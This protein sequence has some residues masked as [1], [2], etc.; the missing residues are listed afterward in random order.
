MA[1]GDGSWKGR[2]GVCHNAAFG[3]S[4]F[5][6]PAGEKQLHVATGDIFPVELGWA[7]NPG[8]PYR[9]HFDSKIRAMIENGLVA[10]VWS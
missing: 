2:A 5:T 3:L 8:S 6:S 7:M 1:F 4:R 10:K 9:H